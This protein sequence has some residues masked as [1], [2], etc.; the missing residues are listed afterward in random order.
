MKG[1]SYSL[2]GSQ[3]PGTSLRDVIESIPNGPQI[4]QSETYDGLMAWLAGL[5]VNYFGK[6]VRLT[7]PP[8]AD[9][10]ELPWTYPFLLLLLRMAPNVGRVWR[11]APESNGGCCLIYGS[12]PAVRFT[13]PNLKDLNIILLPYT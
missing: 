1:T 9:V 11:G 3:R 6:D 2:I 12:N 13:C 7:P 4:Q 5:V 8:D 10:A